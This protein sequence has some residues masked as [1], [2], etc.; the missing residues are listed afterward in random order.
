MR[1]CLCCK[2]KKEYAE[3]AWDAYHCTSRPY[4]KI[5]YSK[6]HKITMRAYNRKKKAKKQ[7]EE[8]D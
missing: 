5:C 7:N 3:F 6:L 1:R 2:L 4:C 8:R